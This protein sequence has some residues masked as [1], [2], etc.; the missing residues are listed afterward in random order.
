MVRTYLPVLGLV[1]ACSVLAGCASDSGTGRSAKALDGIT[2][3]KNEITKGITQVDVTIAALND[4][5][6][7]PK[8]DLMPQ[9]KNF[10]AQVETLDSMA[11]N[12]RER[13]QSMKANTQAYFDAW[14]KEAA[15]MKSEAVRQ[16]SAERRAAARA[17][18]DKMTA[19]V[20]KGKSAFT[21]LM[22]E[23]KDMQ[24]YLSN[25]LTPAGVKACK[26]IAV[27]AEW[28]AVAVKQALNNVVAE[29]A[30]V[31]AELASAEAAPPA[32]E[33]PQAPAA[34]PAAK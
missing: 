28:D 4:I 16:V 27:K 21:P 34:P 24:L 11:K 13:N 3:V 22:D 9:Y 14:Q 8:P 2:V 23:L 15:S 26:P 17:S 12:V 10:A 33:T 31:Q 19:E 6:N 25:D 30:R 32:A 5:V 1:L 20:D 18:F 7:T 29:L